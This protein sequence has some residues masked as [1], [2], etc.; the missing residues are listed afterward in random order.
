MDGGGCIVA[1][2]SLDLNRRHST[3]TIVYMLK[4]KRNLLENVEKKKTGGSNHPLAD[5]QVHVE[6]GQQVSE[7]Q[8]LPAQ[9]CDSAEVLK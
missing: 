2:R 6:T 3:L 1:E 4:K 5:V 7:R 9:C 8:E